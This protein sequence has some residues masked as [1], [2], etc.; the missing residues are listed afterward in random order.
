[1]KEVLLIV[2]MHRSGTSA[3]A[4]AVARL[5]LPL[6]EHLLPGQEGDNPKGFF[7]H[8][9]VVAAH[10]A[11]LGSAGR[12]WDDPT[13]WI[14]RRPELPG[15]D[16]FQARLGSILL[17]ESGGTAPWAVKDPRLCRLLPLWTKPLAEV[18]REP[19]VLLVHRDPTAVAASLR[20]RDGFSAEKASLL[21]LDHVLGAERWSRGLPRT[22]VTYDELLDDPVATLER[23]G[24][25]LG[26]AWPRPPAAGRGEL[27]DFLGRPA[28]TAA[29]DPARSPAGELAAEVWRELE[30]AH[31]G[32]PGVAAL[33]RLAERV[34]GRA[35]RA[36]GLLLEHVGQVVERTVAAR[37]WGRTAPLEERLTRTR[38]AL[39]E[40]AGDLRRRLA[41]VE[42]GLTRAAARADELLG[43]LAAQLPELSAELR[44]QGAV[45]DG[46]RTELGALGGELA[47]VAGELERAAGLAREVTASHQEA[48]DWLAGRLAELEQRRAPVLRRLRAWWRA[49]FPS[50]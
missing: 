8:A 37:L 17:R 34:A 42:E 28:A 11:L 23:A 4:G 47:H 29:P 18:G 32:L 10:D 44:H 14:E 31:P 45:L 26:I 3:V 21:W 20:R 13:L 19:R 16:A 15:A 5:G 25:A 35:H 40:T 1:M 6:G 48:L 27:A 46:T 38:S 39:D 49:S 30:G 36:D 2:G 50:A 22:V 12:T 43:E 41:A 7:E 9:E 33:D 24:E